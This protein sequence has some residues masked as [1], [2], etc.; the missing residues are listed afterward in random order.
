MNKEFE[1][2]VFY[3]E[4][5]NALS[6]YA[7]N[8]DGL[9]ARLQNCYKN[10][11]MN[12]PKMDYDEQVRDIDPFTV[13][14]LFNK[15]ISNESRIKLLTA[16]NQTATQKQFNLNQTKRRVRQMCRAF[17]SSSAFQPQ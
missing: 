14:G 16:I 15:G 5:A 17:S 12:F 7:A 1:W 3:T 4:F 13:F 2:T 11:A 10:V 6:G 8:R 9:I